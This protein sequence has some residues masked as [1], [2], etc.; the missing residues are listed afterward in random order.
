MMKDSV[1]KGMKSSQKEVESKKTEKE[2]NNMGDIK[3]YLE[4]DKIKDVNT[5]HEIPGILFLDLPF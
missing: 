4:S 3:T 1:Q 5:I 2:E